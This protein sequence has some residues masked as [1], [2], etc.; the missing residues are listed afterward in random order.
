MRRRLGIAHGAKRWFAYAPGRGPRPATTAK[1]HP[2]ASAKHWYD[3]VYADA[4]EAVP[5]SCLQRAGDVVYLPA[6]WKHATLNVGETIA[7]GEQQVRE[8][9]FILQRLRPVASAPRA[10]ISCD[11]TTIVRDGVLKFGRE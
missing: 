7:V 6:G 5:T 10:L 11:M 1:L 8:A 9:I 4:D 3:A 2:L